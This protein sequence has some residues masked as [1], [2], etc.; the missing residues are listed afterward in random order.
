[1][2]PKTKAGFVGWLPF[3][4]IAAVILALVIQQMNSARHSDQEKVREVLKTQ[5]DK[6]SLREL[7]A[8]MVLEETKLRAETLESNTELGLDPEYPAFKFP[9]YPGLE[10]LETRREEAQ[11]TLGETMDMWFVHGQVEAELKDIE[12]FYREALTKGDL[13]QT[14]YISIPG[15]YAFNYAN[16]WYDSRFSIEKK[17]TDPIPQVEITVYRVR[18]D[19]V[20]FSD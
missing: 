4:L 17:S 14:Q 12:A 6:L 18:D 3:L 16:E 19:S 9:I 2:E 10:I 5:Q 7:H 13:R 15:G 1:M 11:S 8:A 20:Q